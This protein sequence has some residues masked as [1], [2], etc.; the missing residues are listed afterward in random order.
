MHYFCFLVNFSCFISERKVLLNEMDSISGQRKLT[1][2]GAMPSAILQQKLSS[3][4]RNEGKAVTASEQCDSGFVDDED[5]R[6][7][8][9]ERKDELIRSVE[10]RTEN[11]TID[12]PDTDTRHPSLESQESLLSKNEEL[13][14]NYAQSS[15]VRYLLAQEHIRRQLFLQDDDGDT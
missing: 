3:F 10:E 2:R 9:M 5:L 8:S 11:L 14:L 15:D 12:D 6:C 1:P 7:Q 4:S 13:Y